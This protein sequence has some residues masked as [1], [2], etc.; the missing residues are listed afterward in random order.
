MA[1]HVLFIGWKF[2]HPGREERSLEVFN[3]SIGLLGRMQQDGR[4]ES[5]DVVIM[6]PNADLG[7]Y[8]QAHGTAEQIQALRQDEEFTRLTIDAEVCVGGLKHLEGF[9]GDALARRTGMFQEALGKVRQY[10]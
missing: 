8:M 4:I 3:E 9:T 5:F 6:A 1:D 10:A 2:P 7:G